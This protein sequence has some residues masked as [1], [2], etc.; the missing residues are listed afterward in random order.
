MPTNT[1]LGLPTQHIELSDCTLPYWRKGQGPDLVFIHGW[2]LDARTWRHCVAHLCEHYTCHIIDLPRA[3]LSTWTPETRS[4][5]VHMGDIVAQAISQ[6][7]LP[8]KFGLVAH[9]TGG[10]FSRLAAASMPERIAG[11]VLS[12][13][14]IPHHATMRLH[15]LFALGSM[16]GLERILAWAL[17][18]R[19]GRAALSST[20]PT[21]HALL[22]GELHE[23]FFRTLIEDPHRRHGAVDMLRTVHAKDFD[24]VQ[25]THEQLTAP[26]RLIWGVDD[27]WFPLKDARRMMRTFT[28]EIDIVEVPQA[29]LLVHEEKPEH[30][31][32]ALK[33]HFQRCSFV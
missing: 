27:P 25:Q 26:I 32:Q 17:Q 14:E 22:H 1:S 19:L 3:G 24:I 33:E 15:A 9:D 31:T 20:S 4:G 23:L 8:P 29:G 6:M 2:P 16:P 5:V 18:Q 11:M 13:T 28:A 21:N 12:N 30:F 7:P 10:S